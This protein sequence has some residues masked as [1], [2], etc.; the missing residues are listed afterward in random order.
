MALTH[1]IE[2]MGL[3]DLSFTPDGGSAVDIFGA[4]K[5]SI[6]FDGVAKPAEGDDKTLAYNS[7]FKGAKV[8]F[9]AM[10]VD[11]EALSALTGQTIVDS[12]STPNQTSTL[13]I[14]A[15]PAPFG[16]L[17]GTGVI[18]Q[19]AGTLPAEVEFEIEVFTVIAGELKISGGFEEMWLI[20]AG[21]YAVPNSSDVIV[22]ITFKETAS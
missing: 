13:S 7:A 12:G 3:S 9:E 17:K 4:R 2:L 20:S 5:M 10:A 19:G 16:V 8:S 22:K 21:G 15:A 11:L 14:K 6:E 1:I 18:I